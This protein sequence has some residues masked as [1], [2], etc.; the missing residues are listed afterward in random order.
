MNAVRTVAL[1]LAGGSPV[2]FVALQ[3]AL[4][5]R[6]GKLA[7]RHGSLIYVPVGEPFADGSDP[8]VFRQRLA[9]YAV[10]EPEVNA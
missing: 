10:V 7:R 4:S 6:R 5:G 8:P 3:F 1:G 9:A 2:R